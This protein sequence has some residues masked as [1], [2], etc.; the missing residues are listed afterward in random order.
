[1]LSVV[2]EVELLQVE[3]EQLVLQIQVMVAEEHIVKPMVLLVVQ[4]L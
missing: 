1:M 4:E 2:V 3:A